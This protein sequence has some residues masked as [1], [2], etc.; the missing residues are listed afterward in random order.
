MG[1]TEEHEKLGNSMEG[2]KYSQDWIKKE[3]NKEKKE[4]QEREIKQK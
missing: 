2:I 4:R 3:R 1:K